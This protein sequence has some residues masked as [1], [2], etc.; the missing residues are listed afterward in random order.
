VRTGLENPTRYHVIQKQKSQVRQYLSESF[1]QPLGVVGGATGAGDVSSG[2]VQIQS[3][4]NLATVT[5][6]NHHVIGVSPENA[7]SP[8]LSSVATSTD[9]VSGVCTALTVRQRRRFSCAMSYCVLGRGYIV[10]RNV[11]T[12]QTNNVWADTRQGSKNQSPF[13]SRQWLY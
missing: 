12:Q 7:V 8:S 6:Q 11:T 5:L 2:V 9:E 13:R 10:A 4:P 3:A 1:Q